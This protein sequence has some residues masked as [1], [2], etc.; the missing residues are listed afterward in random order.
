MCGGGRYNG[1]IGRLGGLATPAIGWALGMERLM[2]V[3]GAAAM[4][5]PNGAAARLATPVVP[6][7]YLVNRG[8]HAEASSLFLARV[9]RQ[10]GLNVELDG[11]GSGFGKQFKRA[12]RS[13]ARWAL[14]LGDQ[15]AERGVVR[16]KPLHQQ[17][18]EST[19]AIEPIAAIVEMLRRP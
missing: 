16:L 5:D 11:S 1:L 4:E 14:V 10:K 18:V 8:E 3:M 7:V 19:V 13:G 12:D 2:L 6:D 9:L 15:E 17:G